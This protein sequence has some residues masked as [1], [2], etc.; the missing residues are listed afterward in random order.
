MG[1]LWNTEND[2][3]LKPNPGARLYE[4]P[5]AGH[6]RIILV[7]LSHQCTILR[8]SL[9]ESETGPIRGPIRLLFRNSEGFSAAFS[10]AFLACN[11]ECPAEKPSQHETQQSNRIGPLDRVLIARYV[12]HVRVELSPTLVDRSILYFTQSCRAPTS[13]PCR[14]AMSPIPPSSIL[15]FLFDCVPLSPLAQRSTAV[16]A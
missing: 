6:C 15:P 8:F 9:R 3:S 13:K 11:F 2:V 10:A 7:G 14:P 16:A 1:R 12:L 4:S 5:C